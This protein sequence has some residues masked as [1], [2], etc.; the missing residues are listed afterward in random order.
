VTALL[1]GCKLIF[2]VHGGGAGLD[3]HLHQLERV[4]RAAEPCFRV[5]DDRREPVRSAAPFHVID[6]IRA[7]QRLIDALDDLRH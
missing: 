2:E 1:L 3:H 6:L 4:Q 5:G 7:L